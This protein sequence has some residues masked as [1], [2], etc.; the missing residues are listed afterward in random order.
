MG[1]LPNDS[2]KQRIKPEIGNP[3]DRNPKAE[4]TVCGM[5]EKMFSV[6]SAN[7]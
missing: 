3:N 7:P 5:E 2:L 1:M 4:T 6:A